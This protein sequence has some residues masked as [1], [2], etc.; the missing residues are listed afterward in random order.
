MT[1]QTFLYCFIILL[2]VGQYSFAQTDTTS[3]EES[4]YH[5]KENSK[6]VIQ[7]KSIQEQIQQIRQDKSLSKAEQKEKIKPLFDEMMIIRKHNVSNRQW[8]DADADLPLET[9]VKKPSKSDRKKIKRLQKEI[10]R[11][12]K[13]GTL[14]EAEKRTKLDPIHKEML[15]IKS[16]KTDPPA[17]VH[18][19]IL[20]ADTATKDTERE[21]REKWEADRAEERKAKMNKELRDR[22]VKREKAREKREKNVEEWKAKART[23]KSSMNQS[24]VQKSQ[25][26]KM[27]TK[28]SRNMSTSTPDKI[29]NPNPLDV[30]N[31]PIHSKKAMAK[32]VNQSSMLQRLTKMSDRL[33]VLN[34]KG[35]INPKHFENKMAH[36]RKMRERFLRP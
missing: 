34:D 15:A 13:D 19:R 22:K 23:E 5:N 26:N 4:K 28:G 2:S 17:G 6:F 8:A 29:M 33:T 24:T 16:G 3:K 32:K 25:N 18:G 11:I 10:N 30:S 20:K 1:I 36:I 7:V 27:P 9:D 14:T 31:D 35:L 12:K 21:A